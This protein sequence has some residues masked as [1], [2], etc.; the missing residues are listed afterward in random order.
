MKLH[1]LFNVR[2][3]HRIKGS[4]QHDSGIVGQHVN[5]VNSLFPK[6]APGQGLVRQSGY[7]S[8]SPLAASL[9]TTLADQ[10]TPRFNEEP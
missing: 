8:Q 9:L 3:H 2:F 10:A 6:A 4:P 7:Q 1:C 5:M